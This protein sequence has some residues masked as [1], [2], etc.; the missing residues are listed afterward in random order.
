MKEDDLFSTMKRNAVSDDN[1]TIFVDSVRSLSKHANNIV[2]D[3][4]I[5]NNDLIG[6]TEIQI[7][8]SDSSCKT[9]ETLNFFNSNFNNFSVLEKK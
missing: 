7:S 4:T 6:F 5:T 8:L 9:I 2:S 3:D 1:L